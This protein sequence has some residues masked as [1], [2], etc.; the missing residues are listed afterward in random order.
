[1]NN[2]EL[3]SFENTNDDWLAKEKAYEETISVWDLDESKKLGT[4]HHKYHQENEKKIHVVNKQQ[5]TSTNYVALI[6]V[7]I[8]MIMLLILTFVFTGLDE[9]SFM[10]PIVVFIFLS[11]IISVGGRK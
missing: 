4:E 5:A 1:M 9:L 7:G 10:L 3:E 8:L 11:L 6:I 2:K